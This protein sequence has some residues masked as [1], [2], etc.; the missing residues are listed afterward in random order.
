M[1]KA[2]T[3]TIG[4][5]SLLVA[6]LCGVDNLKT[7]R[8]SE[9]SQNHQVKPMRTVST[10]GEERRSTKRRERARN[11]EAEFQ[12]HLS[13]IEPITTFE[14]PSD[15]Y[16][17]GFSFAWNAL[18]LINQGEQQHNTK[19]E[20]LEQFEKSYAYFLGVRMTAPDW[21]EQMVLARLEKTK[22]SLRE[23]YFVSNT[24]R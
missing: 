14:D 19:R 17:Q 1:K 5:A 10:L 24:Q 22:V 13:K 12:R 15:G 21:K 6:V 11:P 4:V 2:T 16:F 8:H 7:D 9:D 23:A 3:T 18:D 20:I